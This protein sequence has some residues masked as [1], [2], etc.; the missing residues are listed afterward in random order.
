MDH[1]LSLLKA[2]LLSQGESRKEA[3]TPLTNRKTFTLPGNQMQTK[4]NLGQAETFQDG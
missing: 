4:A 2:C 1:C 3:K